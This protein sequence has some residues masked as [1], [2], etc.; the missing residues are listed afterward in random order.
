MLPARAADD[1]LRYG[2]RKNP[3]WCV[4]Y[5]ASKRRAGLGVVT[6]SM[7]APPQP[8]QE[9]QPRSSGKETKPRCLKRA[10]D[11]KL[12]RADQA[13]NAR[14]QQPR[15]S[16]DALGGLVRVLCGRCITILPALYADAR[17][18]LHLVRIGDTVGIKL[19]A[20]LGDAAVRAAVAA[21][22][23]YRAPPDDEGDDDD[24]VFEEVPTPNWLTR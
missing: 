6:E 22:D 1:V 19:P 17:V 8:E 11:H 7:S 4:A 14:I 3:P 20:A 23:V 12:R 18:R 13:A 10:T 24:I 21:A 2:R 15:A 5:L 16:T 9:G